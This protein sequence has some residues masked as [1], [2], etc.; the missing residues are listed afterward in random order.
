MTQRRLYQFPHSHFSEKARWALDWKRL[1]FKKI[2]LTRGPHARITRRYGPETTVPVLVDEDGTAIQDST[3]ILDYLEAT[4][5]NA[6]LSPNDPQD[7]AEA[8]RLEE[9]FDDTLGHHT[10]RFAYAALIDRPDVLRFIW[11]QG[12]GPLMRLA[13]PLLFR[14]IKPR[15]VKRLKLGPGAADESEAE[16]FR[17]MDVI[18]ERL[19]SSDYLVGDRFTRADLTA[20]ALLSLITWPPEHDFN[21]PPPD[22]LPKRIQTFLDTTRERPSTRWALEMY[23]RHRAKPS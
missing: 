14:L 11:L 22:M 2:D 8:L 9:F 20:A 5:P 17:A 21:F 1:P 19:A 15:M 4:Y 13:F 3:A 23:S 16:L 10:R 7:A 18:D 6:P 12:R